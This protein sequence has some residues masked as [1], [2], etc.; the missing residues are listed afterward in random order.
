[1]RA[2]KWLPN[3]HSLTREELCGLS[4]SSLLVLVQLQIFRIALI[5]S[6]THHLLSD[7]H[8]VVH[9]GDAE[10]GL[11]PAVLW[12]YFQGISESPTSLRVVAHEEEVHTKAI[13]GFMGPWGLLESCLEDLG[14]FL[15]LVV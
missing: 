1:M 14:R 5:V 6:E 8:S 12:H 9:V 4:E 3:R 2:P 13:E 7:L 11:I 10:P 15:E